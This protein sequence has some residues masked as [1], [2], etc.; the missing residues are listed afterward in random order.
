[1]SL[2]SV[3]AAGVGITA[4]TPLVLFRAWTWTPQAAQFSPAFEDMHMG[5]VRR[6]KLHTA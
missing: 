5:Q 1:M 4:A 2:D 3:I 6:C